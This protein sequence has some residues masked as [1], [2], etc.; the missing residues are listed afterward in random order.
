MT[1][2]SK[3]QLKAI[4]EAMQSALEVQNYKLT[5][6]LANFFSS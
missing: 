1:N 5:L 6:D 4:R 2:F 3:P